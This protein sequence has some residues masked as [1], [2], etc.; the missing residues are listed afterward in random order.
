MI[1]RSF[2]AITR[3]KSAQSALEQ[4]ADPEY[5]RMVPLWELCDDVFAGELAVK[6]KDAKY[7]YQ[8][9]SKSGKDRRKAWEAYKGRGVMPDYAAS[10]LEKMCGILSGTPPDITFDGKAARLDFLRE[11]ATP[12]HDGLDALADRVRRFVLRSGRYCLL[13]EPDEDEK[14]GFHIN[15]YKCRKFLRAKAVD[16]GGE[17]YAKLVLLDTSSII[18][19][20]GLW[21]DV[22]YPQITLLA[23]DGN[24]VYYQAKFGRKGAPIER[25]RNTGVPIFGD[26]QVYAEAMSEVFNQL[27][28]FNVDFPDESRCSELV[29]PTKYGRTLDRIPFVCVNPGD[30]NFTDYWNPPLLKLCLQSLHILDADCTYKT[31]LFLTG[32]PQPVFTG[33]NK[34]DLKVGSDSPWFIP[35]GATFQFV[36][37]SGSGLTE[38]ANSL[39]KMKAEAQLMGVSLAG[40]EN[41]GNTPVGTMQLYR[42][43]QTA[44]LMRINQNCGKAIE[45]ILRFAGKWLGMND[46]ECSRDIKFTPSNEFAEIKATAAECVQIGA[47]DLPMTQ[48]EKRRYIEKNNIVEPRPWDEVM[49]ELEAEKAER[50]ENS[51]NSVAGAFGMSGGEI[52]ADEADNQNPDDGNELNPAPKK[53][54]KAEEEQ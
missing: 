6:A 51:L 50:M 52:P 46:E 26:N 2:D 9:V 21:K 49:E 42:N 37:P 34:S 13:L 5:S 14:I 48:E 4:L 40:Q 10:T 17:T 19:E 1:T 41:L 28:G 7:I 53:A 45:I 16:G 15:E 30:L 11:Y 54:Q 24:G 43:S 20:T 36:S 25:Y 12:Y 38:Q 47:S 3:K 23:L 22:Y 32:D 44:D 8:P 27:E 29:Y 39:E 33:M 31:A 18:Y 35:Q